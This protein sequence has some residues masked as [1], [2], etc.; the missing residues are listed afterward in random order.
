MRGQ[1]AERT[2]GSNDTFSHSKLSRI[3]ANE[4][5]NKQYSRFEK[6]NVSI[7]HENRI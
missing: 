7:H 4:K 1:A 6:G 5:I 2:Q 3:Q